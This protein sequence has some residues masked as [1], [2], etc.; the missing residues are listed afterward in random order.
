MAR[1]KFL[2][3]RTILQV[4]IKEAKELGLTLLHNFKLEQPSCLKA[5]MDTGLN[6]FPRS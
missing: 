2:Q 1:H 5:Q 3:R 6:L 4:F